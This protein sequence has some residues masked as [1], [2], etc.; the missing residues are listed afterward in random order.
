MN[1][2]FTE[3]ELNV[4]Q[5]VMAESLYSEARKNWGS[6]TIKYMME[7]HNKLRMRDYCE[8]HNV[9]YEDLTDEDYEAEYYERYEA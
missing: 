4:I 3:R 5:H 9:K 7:I 6:E 1:T 2:N 8:R